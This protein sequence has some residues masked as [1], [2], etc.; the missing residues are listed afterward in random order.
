[1]AVTFD[2]DFMR[3]LESLN[4]IARKVFAGLL[5]AER[6]SRKTGSSVEFA[7]YRNY[8]PGDDFRHI[9]WNIYARTEEILLKLFREEENLQ[10]SVFI[11]CSASMDFGT[12]NKFDYARM[13][14]GAMSYIGLANLDSVNLMTFAGGLG[15]RLR[16][17]R[18]KPAIFRT[19]KFIERLSPERTTDL[20]TSLN[21]FMALVRRRG[22]QIVLS[23][24]YAF[25]ET[26]RALRA[27]SFLKNDVFLIHV[28]DPWEED[29][30]L[31]GELRLRDVELDAGE[32]LSIT[33]PL[34]R[35]YREA[36]AEHVRI[37]ERTCRQNEWGY[38]RADTGV[39]YDELIL[40]MLRKQGLVR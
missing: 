7:D 8:V 28:V 23:D 5:R 36:F 25:E 2:S 1:M 15:A 37:V 18:G 16:G 17:A 35:R 12:H 38:L 21:Q 9:D 6:Q 3:R 22:V 14:A 39:P 11:D 20:A 30:D 10:L 27:L 40:R 34:L 33:R 13:V 26:V 24:F 19:L 31:A 32:N 4:I 29:P